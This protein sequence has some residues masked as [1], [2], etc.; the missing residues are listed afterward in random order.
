[1]VL[2]ES[3]QSD[4]YTRALNCWPGLRLTVLQLACP[5]SSAPVVVVAVCGLEQLR[6]PVSRRVDGDDACDRLRANVINNLRKQ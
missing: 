2:A 6:L 3:D 5:A 4:P 1:M